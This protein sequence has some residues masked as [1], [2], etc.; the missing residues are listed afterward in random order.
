MPAVSDTLPS[1]R[2]DSLEPEAL[3]ADNGRRTEPASL[4]ART[5]TRLA[6]TST[7]R[8]LVLLVVVLLKVVVL[9]E[10]SVL[11][12][13]KVFVLLEMSVLLKV[14]ETGTPDA[15]DSLPVLGHTG[16]SS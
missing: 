7:L 12:L 16:L 4:P 1:L 3:E 13:L 2:S 5:G 9:S 6:C 8:P 14:W 10:M 15:A 11:V